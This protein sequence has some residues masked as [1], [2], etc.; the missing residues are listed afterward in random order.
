MKA[1][2]LYNET[3]SE[4]N[5]RN[6]K[7]F[8]HIYSSP[9]EDGLL[10]R[11]DQELKTI[12]NLIAITIVLFD[13]K[14]LAFAVM[15]NHLHFIM[16]GSEEECLKFFFSLIER[17]TNYYR[18][19]GRAGLTD[20]IQPGC[21]AISSL[22]QLRNEIAYVLRNPY[23][24]RNDVNPLACLSTSGH[25]YFNPLLRRDG[26]PADTLKGRALREF[27][28][29]HKPV[30]SGGGIYVLDGVAQAWSFVDY[31]RTMGFFDNAQQFV[32]CLLK[33]VEAQ[34]EIAMRYN[35]TI[36]LNDQELFTVSMK[37][38]R[39]LFN[40]DK[41]SELGH[42]QKMMLAMNLKRRYQVPNAQLSRVCG[43]SR[44]EVDAMFPLSVKR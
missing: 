39:N 40:C 17:L 37:L 1:K 12:I 6:A 27:T 19:N 14:I 41:L 13:C 16:E 32:I 9:L 3:Q 10:Y 22:E 21:K 30:E 33:N 24:S 44:K 25:L 35:D 38:V 11:N 4:I 31:E 5:F 26:V 43:L 29:T 23:V 34:I 2:M 18:R 28:H 42:Q 8:F 7:Q 15:S 36:S 20:S